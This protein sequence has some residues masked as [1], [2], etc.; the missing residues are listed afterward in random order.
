[1]GDDKTVRLPSGPAYA[2]HVL[3]EYRWLAA[4]APELPVRIPEPLALGKPSRDFPWHWTVNDWLDGKDVEGQSGVDLV[5]LASDLAHFLKSLQ[6][7]DATDAPGPSADNFFRGAHPSVYHSETVQYL[8]E[9]DGLI[10]V[11]VAAKV[12]HQAVASEW[13]RSPVWV[14]GDFAASNLLVND[15]G[16]CGVIDFGQLAA[17]DPACDLAIAWTL[18]SGASRQVFRDELNIGQS[19]WLRGRGWA[20]WKALLTLESHQQGDELWEA[21]DGVIREILAESE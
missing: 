7:I 6:S 13:S 21:A 1:M 16:L 10:D 2:S 5:S 12:W 19:T 8:R 11:T 14:H 9:L 18:L 4:L 17:G 20:L 3:V 15:A